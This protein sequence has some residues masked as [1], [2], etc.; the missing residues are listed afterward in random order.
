MAAPWFK[1]Q[2][3][4]TPQVGTGYIDD[5]S[6]E[7]GGLADEISV[8]FSPSGADSAFVIGGFPYRFGEE[9]QIVD[10]AMLFGG[11]GSYISGMTFGVAGGIAL[12]GYGQD[13]TR[14][15]PAVGS[16]VISG[17]SA[18]SLVFSPSGAD[19]GIVIAGSGPSIAIGRTLVVGG[20]LE[21]DGTVSGSTL[22]TVVFD[23]DGAIEVGGTIGST[24]TGTHIVIPTGAVKVGRA[25]VPTF[26]KIISK[27]SGPDGSQ[28]YVEY[29]VGSAVNRGPTNQTEILIALRQL[30]INEG[31]FTDSS[32]TV[33]TE[34]K[35]QEPDWTPIGDSHCE[36]RLSPKITD[37]RLFDGGGAYSF[38]RSETVEIRVYH[39]TTLDHLQRST[40]WTSDRIRGVYPKVKEVENLVTDCDLRAGGVGPTTLA[41]GGSGIILTGEPM[42]VVS[43]T[44]PQSIQRLSGWGFVSLLV[45]LKYL[46]DYDPEL[47]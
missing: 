9:W 14:T 17:L 35:T 24:I 40:L 29:E 46:T 8:V 36:I 30:F 31:V 16:I 10:P 2:Q 3:I 5:A 37:M 27:H 25:V 43:I 18:T 12:S 38:L 13:F 33:V 22:R 1:W 34:P 26:K 42:R 4:H 6:I 15:F 19:S 21:I 28:Q 47:T 44:P 39:R 7:L 41:Q 32:I 11:S 20:A 23:P 45:E